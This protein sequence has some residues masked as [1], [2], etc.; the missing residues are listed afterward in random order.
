M[1]DSEAKANLGDLLAH[2]ER[3]NE[4]EN[5]LKEA[6]ALDGDSV[7]GNASMG[8]L[9]MRQHRFDEAQR[10]L[11]KAAA[12]DRTSY[13]V[14]YRYAY[15]ISREFIDSRNII[16]HYPA[17]AA[18][19]MRYALATAIA[20]NP[21]FPDS[22]GLLAKISLVRNEKTEEGISN[23]TKAISLAPGNQVYKLNLASLY[24]KLGQFDKAQSV[25]ESVY[26][27][28]ADDDIR[29]RATGMMASLKEMRDQAA[30]MIAAGA[31]R[32]RVFSTNEDN[33]PTEE[34]VAKLRAEF[35]YEAIGNALRKPVAG[36]TRIVGYLSRIDCAGADDIVYTIK[37]G[38]QVL[39]LYS[40]DFKSLV[41]TAL[42]PVPEKRIDC[43][44]IKQE[45]FAILTFR[46]KTNPRTGTK[47]ELIAIEVIPE[48][49]KLLE[50]SQ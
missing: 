22:Y 1:K 29:A 34:E 36:E 21:S 25:M 16:T 30:G 37:A 41:F 48:N 31:G 18:T 12:F 13:L 11:E 50:Y 39:R 8:F 28:A 49:F 35:E 5:L 43:G 38:D 9:R 14:H 46:P 7:I 23:L 44:G 17:E 15:A 2:S 40:R 45:F 24:M 6:L 32:S 33:P 42:S 20:L 19:K 27:S 4:A 26:G 47:G 10:Y 3:L